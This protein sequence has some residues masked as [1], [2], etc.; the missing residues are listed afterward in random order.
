MLT[1]NVNNL[2]Q[3][4]PRTPKA[5]WIPLYSH[6]FQYS[7]YFSKVINIIY[8]CTQISIRLLHRLVT[9]PATVKS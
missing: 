6:T 1:D 5:A 8:C 4:I 9:S 3:Y 2:L 7:K